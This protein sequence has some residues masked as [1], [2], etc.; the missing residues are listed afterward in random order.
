MDSCKDW[1]VT[2]DYGDPVYYGTSYLCNMTRDE[3]I[4]HV[5]NNGGSVVKM[6]P[7]KG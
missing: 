7:N 1:I 2:V 4:Q 5:R 3:V 6:V